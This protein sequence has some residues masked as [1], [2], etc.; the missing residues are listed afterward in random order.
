M[1]TNLENNTCRHTLGSHRDWHTAVARPPTLYVHVLTC[2]T[3]SS[4]QLDFLYQLDTPAGALLLYLVLLAFLGFFGCTNLP[5]WISISNCDVRLPSARRNF[6]FSFHLISFHL[7]TAMFCFAHASS[8]PY[9]AQLWLLLLCY[10]AAQAAKRY[11]WNN[12]FRLPAA[13]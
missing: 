9:Y 11:M 1:P 10:C 6:V 8:V 4:R 5:V 12:S 3:R 13:L 7:H 2:N